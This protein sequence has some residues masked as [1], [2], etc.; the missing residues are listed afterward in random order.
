M[1]GIAIVIWMIT[2]VVVSLTPDP[3][4]Q[5]VGALG[6]FVSGAMGF[7]FW[8]TTRYGVTNRHLHL[9]RG[10]FYMRIPLVEI[11]AVRRTRNT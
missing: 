8:S 1:W 7:Y 6:G 3:V 4:A 5:F 2:A 10:A 11:K 9:H